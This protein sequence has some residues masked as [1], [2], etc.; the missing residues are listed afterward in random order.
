MKKLIYL[1]VFVVI[2]MS[3]KTSKVNCDA[4]S[5]YEIQ[6]DSTNTIKLTK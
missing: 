3:C 1:L 4:Y 6:K 5:S 2:L